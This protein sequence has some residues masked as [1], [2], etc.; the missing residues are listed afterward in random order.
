MNNN[1][2]IWYSAYLINNNL[3]KGHLSSLQRG[4]DT[5][6]ENHLSKVSPAL[7]ISKACH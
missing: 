1:V 7:D 2:I 4:C 6:V 5:Q 3:W